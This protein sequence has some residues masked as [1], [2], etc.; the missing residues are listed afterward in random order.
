MSSIQEA[1][2]KAVNLGKQLKAIIE[3]G[4]CLEELGSLE[5]AQFEA[6]RTATEAKEQ[7]AI[8]VKQLADLQMKTIGAN[9]AYRDVQESAKQLVYDSKLKATELLDAAK[10]TGELVKRDAVKVA[11][12]TL[13]NMKSELV[14]L[15]EQRD[16]YQVEVSQL[17]LLL[18]TGNTELDALRE[19][20]G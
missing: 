3:V 13:A 12:Q 17:Q 8:E 10:F 1:S 9:E 19:K 4:E 7:C 6:E 14:I 11:E 5:L 2:K 18:Q 20:L 15:S 16:K